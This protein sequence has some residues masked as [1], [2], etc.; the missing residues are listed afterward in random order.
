[1][2]NAFRNLFGITSGA[3]AEQASGSRW[4]LVGRYG[5]D[6][7]L[8]GDALIAAVEAATGQSTEGWRLAPERDVERD[9]IRMS[10]QADQLLFLD[11]ETCP[12]LREEETLAL[13]SDD[14]QC[15]P[16]GM[17]AFLR[18]AG[19]I[20]PLDLTTGRFA[21]A[22]NPPAIPRPAHD[23]AEREPSRLS[24]GTLLTDIDALYE[25][26]TFNPMWVSASCAWPSEQASSAPSSRQHVGLHEEAVGIFSRYLDTDDDEEWRPLGGT[27]LISLVVRFIADSD[28]YSAPPML[29]VQLMPWDAAWS[30]YR[31]LHL[32]LSTLVRLMAPVMPD[33]ASLSLK[34]EAFRSL[35]DATE[36]V[37][38][39]GWTEASRP[40]TEEQTRAILQRQDAEVD[41]QARTIRQHPLIDCMSQDPEDACPGML[42]S[43]FL[44]RGYVPPNTVWV[45][46]L[47]VTETINAALPHRAYPRFASSFDARVNWSATEMLAAQAIRLF[48]ERDRYPLRVCKDHKCHAELRYEIVGSAVSVPRAARGIRFA[49]EASSTSIS[50]LC[51]AESTLHNWS[52]H[53]PSASCAPATI[54]GSEKSTEV[55]GDMRCGSPVRPPAPERSMRT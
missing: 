18:R 15:T 5:P 46:S 6:A 54:E 27:K 21:L 24:T 20:V 35:L 30:S 23:Q 53:S 31:L 51:A 40:L 42:Q 36:P 17:L 41:N 26:P 44:V 48:G 8:T 25:P 49:D 52:V 1:M 55:S 12:A 28:P 14:P 45:L 2:S 16:E 33:K 43:L 50:S 47:F 38:C 29:R 13:L 4:R 11:A 7:P 34:E 22:G 32:A 37:P 3:T 10:S 39:G 19:M 9:L